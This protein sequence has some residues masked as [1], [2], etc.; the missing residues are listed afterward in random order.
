LDC[1]KL[2]AIGGLGEPQAANMRRLMHVDNAAFNSPNATI[3]GKSHFK[4]RIA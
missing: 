1:S 2:T 4:Y 3:V